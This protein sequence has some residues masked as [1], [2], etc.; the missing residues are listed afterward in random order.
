MF[1]VIEGIDGTGKTSVITSIETFLLSKGK[2]VTTT[3]EPTGCPI[4]KMVSEMDDLT[5]EAEAL[6]F[7]ADR[8][9]H[10]QEIK[11]WIADDR[12]VVSDRYY[13]STLAYQSAAG[14]DIGWLEAINSK[15][16]MEPDVTIILDMDPEESLRRV[17]ER[18]EK[19]RFEK[20]DYQREVRKAY[21][22]LAERKGYS[23]VDA[24]QSREKV[25]DDVIRIISG[26]L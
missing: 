10:T 3:R 19:S 1:I 17:E 8:A 11:R 26:R 20:L 5:P 24:S 22:E 25:S 12:V 2:K 18:G 21:L 7:T 15:V 23:I 16:I 13:A 9:V 14:L 4:G 6:L